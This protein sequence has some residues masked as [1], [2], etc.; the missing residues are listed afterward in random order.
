MYKTVGDVDSLLDESKGKPVFI[1]KHSATCAI[2][3]RA[4]RQ[5]DALLELRNDRDIYL[6]IVQKEREISRQIAESLN[7]KHESPHF[8]VIREKKAAHV[9]NH[10]AITRAAVE[11][12][13]QNPESRIQ[14]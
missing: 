11:E 10:G 13:I 7:V 1:L 4:K 12:R 14:K 3:A 2:S 8:L 5:V 6:V 9:L